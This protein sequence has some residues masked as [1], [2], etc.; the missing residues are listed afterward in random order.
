M[1]GGGK[2]STSSS[3]VSIPPEVLA[4]YNA[5][6]ARAETTAQQ[7]FQEYGGEFV[8]PLS[9][10]QQA[11]ISST[12]TAAGQAQ[13]YYN[14]ATGLTMSGAQDVGPLTQ[15][16]IGYYQ[17]PYTQAVVDPTVKALQ[18]QF[19]QQNANQQAQA[20]KAGGLGGGG[21]ARARAMLSGQQ[22]LA[23]SQ[24]IAPLYQKGYTDAADLA[25]SQQGVVAAD[26]ARRMQAGTQIAN[27]GTGAQTAGLQGAAAQLAAGQTEQQTQQALDT[28]KYQQFLQQQRYP[29]DVTQFLAN[30]AEGTGALS[31][32]T[33]TT[34]SPRGLFGNRGGAFT[35]ERHA[36]FAGGGLVPEGF[37]ESSMGGAVMPEME[38]MGFARGGYATDGGVGPYGGNSMLN[39]GTGI[40]PP[41]MQNNNKLMVSQVKIPEA[42]GGLGDALQRGQQIAGMYK[43]GKEGLI[44]TPK[45]ASDPEGG[46]GLIGGQGQWG[47]QNAFSKLKDWMKPAVAHG[48]LILEREHHA[49]YEGNVA[50]DDYDENGKP[51]KKEMDNRAEV[52]ETFLTPSF[53]QAGAQHPTLPT[54]GGGGGGKSSSTIGQLGQLAGAGNAAM[55]LGKGAAGLF[56]GAPSAIPE[57]IDLTT[58]ALAGATEAAGGTGLLAGIGEGL[59]SLG[60]FLLPFAKDGGRI[61]HYDTG[62]LVPREH[63]DGSEGNVAGD[64]APILDSA[65]VADQP[66][67]PVGALAAIAPDAKIPAG[68]QTK[69]KGL[70]V[71]QPDRVPVRDIITRHASDRGVDPELALKIAG[72]E[73]SF[74]P[75]G[76]AS[77]STAGGLF[78]I[79]DKTWK[80][81]GGAPG[82]KYDPEENARVGVKII[83]DNQAALRDAGFEPT[84]GNTY[85]AHFLG[86]SGAKSVLANP[87]LPISQ[88]L[89]NYTRAVKSNPKLNMA[90]WT[91]NDAINWANA[92]MS[93]Q[94]F[95]APPRPPGDVGPSAP[96]PGLLP[97]MSNLT[98]KVTSQGFLVPALGFLGSMLSSKSRTLAGALGEGMLG[99]V[100]A[101]MANQK[102]Q[103][104]MAKDLRGMLDSR[105]KAGT[106]PTTVGPDGKPIH[107][108]LAGKDGFFDTATQ[109]W[110]SVPDM[111]KGKT[112]V[113]RDAG[114]SPALLG[115]PALPTIEAP[116]AP[117]APGAPGTAA[118]ATAAQPAQAGASQPGQPGATQPAQPAQPSAAQPVAAP[119]QDI[120]KMSEAQLADRIRKGGEKAYVD[121]GL[122]GPNDP[123]P[124]EER[125]DAARKAL[126]NEGTK[127]GPE[128]EKKV[129]EL[130]T[131]VNEL[132]NNIRAMYRS[133]LDQQL[134]VNKLEAQ[135]RNQA[136]SE[137][138]KDA[139]SR[140]QNYDAARTALVNSANI[141]KDY[142][143][144]ILSDAKG[145]VQS[146]FKDLGIENML[147]SSFSAMSDQAAA[148]FAIS[149]AF[150]MVH[151]SSLVRAPAA[152]LSRAEKVTAQ[153]TMDPGAILSIVGTTV[154][155]MDWMRAR[156]RAYI[157]GD[158]RDPGKHLSKWD[159][160]EPVR[161][162]NAAAFN[163]L[164]KPKGMKPE[165]YAKMVRDYAFVPNDASLSSYT[166]DP[167]NI[168]MKGRIGRVSFVG[169][170][171]KP[172]FHYFSLTPER[173]AEVEQMQRA[174]K[175]NQ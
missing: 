73:S 112:Q 37:D 119:E 47:G 10:T 24:A 11:G 29:F 146:L 140:L 109:Q 98:D 167:S 125:L 23:F 31:G 71:D 30:I 162:Y 156:D 111:I 134:E 123:R 46:A 129:G 22:D 86:A 68:P 175:G 124:L 32:S 17:N 69:Q 94:K 139:T 79:V 14:A 147:P 154:G 44:G 27:L 93:G 97:D 20:I 77:T 153:P 8:S 35:G 115:V 2:T 150:K 148:K 160:T 70:A 40:V 16:Q 100:G 163:E 101:H 122:V 55:K 174:N 58:P 4:R 113:A 43:F 75:K 18:Q 138:K 9:Q 92:K 1:S 53:L 36:K 108:A 61:S 25:K 42:T 26:L 144:G 164:P 127:T 170:D 159:Q 168:T 172:G 45:T 131:Q 80:G 118:Q 3:S 41:P 74:S 19:G 67:L 78:G 104:E 121:A 173:R 166:T 81:N 142:Q 157:D 63:H 87:D 64:S 103:I 62:G 90:N 143:A 15:G 171:G 102:Q 130:T 158:M 155:E 152:T 128:A 136:H 60:A 76:Q 133:A 51:K 149:Q 88:T 65:I 145:K 57:V 96:S 132:T 12:N 56:G 33:T 151:D 21:D 110:M 89:S 34:T 105:F 106:V 116:K 126:T 107:G 48:G 39:A 59:G 165:E 54:A 135:S 114:V 6:N 5:V 117:G 84:H 7:P 52:P 95:D 72:R 38:G 91:G 50:G 66:G 85:L 141:Y 99:G 28:A 13:P 161:L 49:G 169:P 120:T 83:A 82:L 137:F